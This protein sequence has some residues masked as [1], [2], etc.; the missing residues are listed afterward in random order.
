MNLHF[1]A[2]ARRAPREDDPALTSL[3][4]WLAA[5][6]NDIQPAAQALA[7]RLLDMN[8]STL[9]VG[10]RLQMLEACRTHAEPL[11]PELEVPLEQVRPPLAQAS[12]HRAYLIEK[13]EKELAAGYMRVA[14]AKSPA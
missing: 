14:M 13:L 8:R 9:P 1:N 7:A 4:A 11:L 3:R 5:L 12:R 2:A 10:L 6:P